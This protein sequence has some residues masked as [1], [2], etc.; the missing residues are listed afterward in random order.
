M[1]KHL[2]L[3]ANGNKVMAKFVPD[4][5]MAHSFQ[6]IFNGQELLNEDIIMLK[7]ELYERQLMK[8]NPDWTYKHAHEIVDKKYNYKKA[9]DM[10]KA[11]KS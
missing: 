4:I 9:V 11:K 1:D 10:R 3:D 5:D 2:T 8:A 7:H 6:R